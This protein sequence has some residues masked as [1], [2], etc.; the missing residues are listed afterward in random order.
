ME[1]VSPTEFSALLKGCANRDEFDDLVYWRC[2]TDIYLFAV[3]F[4][5]HYCE[6]PFNDFHFDQFK[7][8]EYGERAVRRSDAAPR[9]YAKSAIKALFKPIHDVCYKLERFIVI[10]SNTEP[11]SVQKLKDIA[12]EFF[13]N[14]DLIRIYGRFVKTKSVGSTDFISNNNGFKTRFL[15]VGS[16]KEIRGARFGAFRPSKIIIDDFEHSTEVENEEIRDKYDAIFKDVFSK[17]GNRKTNIEMIGTVLHRKAL[18]V[19]VMKNPAYTGKMYKA[20]ESWSDR[21][22]LWHKWEEIYINIDGFETA[23]ERFAVAKQFYLD[24][25]EEMLSGVQV[26]WPEHE[27]Y[28]FLMCEIIETGLRSFMKEK[29]NSPMSDDEKIFDPERMQEY[30]EKPDGLYITETKTLIPW[31]DLDICCCT[32]DP[33]TGQTKAKKGKKGDF[34]CILVGYKDRK[35]RLFVHWDYTKRAAPSKY[36][37]TIFEL[38][39]QFD[40]YKLGVETNL[41]RN[42]LMSNIQDEKSRRLKTNSKLSNLRFYDIIQVEN[43]E[44]RIYTLEPKVEYGKILFNKALSQEFYDQMWEFPKGDHDDCPDALEMLWSLVHNRYE[45]GPINKSSNK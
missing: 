34:T 20:I 10:A 26:L 3:T 33:A 8:Y 36:I 4:F 13:D 35:G 6:Y 30:V 17:I 11:Q 28:Y 32:I 7:E 25:E 23:K 41:Y 43:K 18:L 12:A 19:S 15:A 1:K 29:Q 5:P 31:R 27:D 39:E 45:A 21:K 44:K 14:D 2:A 40:F 38:H 24:N 9:G 42:L 22:D 16:K 37:K